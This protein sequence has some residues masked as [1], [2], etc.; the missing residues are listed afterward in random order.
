MGNLPP[1]RITQAKPFEHTGVDYRG[2]LLM[3]EKKHRNCNKVK[4]WISIFV[5]FTTK[6]VHIEIVDDS[7]TDQFLAAFSRFISRHPACNSM[8]SDNGTNYVGAKN[9]LTELFNL[10]QTDEHNEKIQRT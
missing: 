5:C 8:Y 10:V 6:A 1:E 2:P 3:K 7:S 9:E 4:V